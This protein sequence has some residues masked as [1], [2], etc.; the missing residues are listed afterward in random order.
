VPTALDAPEPRM[1]L[2]RRSGILNVVLPSP[3]PQR[4]PIIAKRSDFIDAI[5]SNDYTKAFKFTGSDG[6]EFYLTEELIKYCNQFK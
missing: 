1:N 5:A 2:S 4:V 6:R 3:L